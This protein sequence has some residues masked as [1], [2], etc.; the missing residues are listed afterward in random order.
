MKS[1]RLSLLLYF[2][3]LLAA[4]LGAVSVLVYRTAEQSLQD[5][6]QS[7]E[8]L[9]KA[10]YEER[11]RLEGEKLDEALLAEARH[12]ADLVKLQVP[13]QLPRGTALYALGLL[14]ASV[15][16]D[17][18]CISPL[19][20]AEAIPG[21][22]D[23]VASHVRALAFT[24]HLKELVVPADRDD[25][26]THYWQI[27]LPNGERWRSPSMGA[28][29]FPFDPHALP[30]QRLDWK[31][32]DTALQPGQPLRRVTLKVAGFRVFFERTPKGPRG[33][34]AAKAAT[35]EKAAGPR[36]PQRWTLHIQLAQ[37]TA[38][39]DAAVAGFQEQLDAERAGKAAEAQA[40][41]LDLG[42]RLAGISLLTFAATLVGG[43]WLVWLGLRPLHRLTEAVSHISEKD[44]RLPLPPAPLP[45]ELRPIAGRLRQTLDQLKA[46]FAREKQA[47][48]DI[49][50]ELRTPLAALLT[51]LD[52]AL[53][54]PRAPEEYR[55]VLAECR[56]A[57]QQMTEL[58][59]KLL[60]LARLEAGAAHVRPRQVDAVELAEQCGALVRPLAEARGLALEVRHDG[61]ATLTTDPEKL[62]E[63][64]TN[65]LHNA[66]AYNRP[67]GRVELTVG[68]DNGRLDLLVTDTG[69][70]IPEEARAHI[71]ERF[72]RA[73]PAR[74]ADGAHA[75]IGL[76]IVKGYVDLLGGT[77]RVDSTVGKGST[78]TV[79]LPANE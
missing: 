57:G 65:L 78:F 22:P 20:V 38:E 28:S 29:A 3:V 26:G 72:Y 4:A 44:F 42:A 24:P 12:L 67:Q 62:R 45:E 60:A 79:S 16:P 76:A 71:F 13:A 77:V 7:V 63:V 34:K 49:S 8:E 36:S 50:H 64:L 10:R 35:D 39:R 27:D 5:R 25:Q 9:L 70:G 21:K 55:R 32:D 43:L 53:R 52:V 74:Q 58:V 15:G 51:T 2:A 40:G 68:R 59:E 33:P 18:H 17:A 31:L 19:W 61:P 30:G 11:R 37:P 41:L 56:A 75:G 48:A 46:A 14:T 1:I 23:D 54:K 47:A 69:V 6:Q 66:I 73:D